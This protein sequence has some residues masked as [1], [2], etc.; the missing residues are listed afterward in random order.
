[1]LPWVLDAGAMALG[2]TVYHLEIALSDTDRG[3]YESL[4]LRIAR[5][6]SET[7]RY[8]VTRTLAYALLHEEGIAFSKGLST[9]DE[10]AVWVREADGRVRLWVGVGNPSA[11]RLHRASK[12]ADRV[13]V[14]TY[15]APSRLR[16]ALAGERIHR[17][18][19]VELVG[20]P[21]PL[22]DDLGSA[23]GRH[24]SWELVHTGGQVYVTVGGRTFE[25]ALVREPLAGANF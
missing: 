10:P 2:A 15:D 6:P 20:V 18:E 4:D 17:A 25:G 19:R 23:T 1:L 21:T 12:G 22:L 5:H 14:F 7:M 16:Q 24:A 11:D 13:V 9:N 8:L 3:V